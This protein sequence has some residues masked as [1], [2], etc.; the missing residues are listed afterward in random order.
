MR[1]SL[2]HD[3]SVHDHWFSMVAQADV[4]SVGKQQKEGCMRLARPGLALGAGV[5]SVPPNPFNGRFSRLLVKLLIRG[6]YAYES[7]A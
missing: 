3:R 7:I 4:L 6:R 5:Q 2:R 1:L